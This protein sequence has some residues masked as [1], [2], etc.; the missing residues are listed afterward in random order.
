MKKGDKVEV[1][2]EDISGIITAIA[3]DKVTI[4]S[5]D[6]FEMHYLKN[7]LIVQTGAFSRSQ[8]FT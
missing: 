3:G 6:G 7:E 1:L 5:D 2:D 8:M 4:L